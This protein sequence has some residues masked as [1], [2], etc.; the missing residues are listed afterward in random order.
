[1]ASARV[2]VIGGG[3]LAR[4]MQQAA[5]ALDIELVVLVEDPESGAGTAIP[6]H[7]VGPADSEVHIR[8]LASMTDVVTV[9]HEVLDLALMGRLADEG[10]VLRPGAS[11]LGIAADKLAQKEL[12]RQAGVPSPAH[13]EVRNA[14]DLTAARDRLGGLV[15]KLARGGY[16]GRGVWV[17]PDPDTAA[18]V[19]SRAERD[20]IPVLAERVVDAPVELA[21]LVCR[22]PA[23]QT[24]VYDPVHTFQVD[25]MCREVRAPAGLQAGLTRRAAELAERVASAAGAVGIMAVELFLAGDELLV[26]EIAP[27]PHNSGHHTIDAAM[28]SQFENHLRA[29]LDLPLG[30]PS[31]RSPAAMVNLV[32][33]EGMDPRRVLADGLAVDAGVRVHLYDKEPRPGRKIGHVTVCDDDPERASKR[34]WEVAQSLGTTGRVPEE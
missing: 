2:G 8:R 32:G 14:A 26:N 7:V 28:T 29:V 18:G 4:M 20:R 33:A 19:V 3:Q 34:A 30:D 5:V 22:S 11:T 21:V 13:V 24:V 9:D 27:R 6:R 16:D 25:G 31:L 12:F 1:M 23:G 17:L 10:L 15:L